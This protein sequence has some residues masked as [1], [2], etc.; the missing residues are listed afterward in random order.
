VGEPYT[1]ENRVGS[2]SR[3]GDTLDYP[4]LV[5]GDPVADTEAATK[6][7]VDT[8][9]V[10]G[11]GGPVPRL[12]GRWYNHF[13]CCAAVS[14]NIAARSCRAMIYYAGGQSTWENIAVA[15]SSMAAPG[16]GTQ[17]MQLGA[18]TLNPT[19]YM[20]DQ[21]IYLSPILPVE[22]TADFT[23]MDIHNHV[24]TY[25]VTDPWFYL[26]LWHGGAGSAGYDQTGFSRGSYCWPGHSTAGYP[27]DVPPVWQATSAT[28][29]PPSG[30]AWAMN[31]GT[32]YP[33]RLM[34]KL[35]SRP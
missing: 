18:Y 6:N 16:L 7:Y 22:E 17:T 9:L 11:P 24:C 26:A 29:L 25:S 12:V 15:R 19:T 34:T 1:S 2:V 14:N 31:T 8:R 35:K 32:V 5:V 27:Y 33:V 20:P 28:G 13:L 4:I 10:P 23:G 3:S 30:S 21:V